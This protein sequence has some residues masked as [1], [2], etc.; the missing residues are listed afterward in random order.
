MD[1]YLIPYK[2]INSRWVKGL[3]KRLEIVHLFEENLRKTFDISFGSVFF[4][5]TS[6][7]QA[8]KKRQMVL[9]QTKM[10]LKAKEIINSVKRQPMQWQLIFANIQGIP[11]TQ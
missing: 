5:L 10:L 3:N 7:A 8:T 9:H 11:T 6:R 1:P 2:N 4:D